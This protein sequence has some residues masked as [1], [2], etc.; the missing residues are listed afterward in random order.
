M[1]KPTVPNKRTCLLQSLHTSDGQHG[2]FAI[3]RKP[4][5]PN[6]P[7]EPC[8]SS[9]FSFLQLAQVNMG[10]FRY[11]LTQY[12][13]LVLQPVPVQGFDFAPS[14]NACPEKVGRG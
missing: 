2:I 7:T 1:I 13:W 3:K 12:G 10:Q 5:L 11:R 6:K 8:S 14:E 4:M 9:D